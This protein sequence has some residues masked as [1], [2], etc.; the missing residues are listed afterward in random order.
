MRVAVTGS[1]GF[2]GGYVTKA[3]IQHG[4]DVIELSSDLRDRSALRRDVA[5]RQFDALIHLAGSAFAGSG[6]WEDFF[7]INHLGTCNLLETVADFYP[8]AL[9][10]LASTAQVY[11]NRVSG[12]IEE[13]EPFQPA[14]PYGISK[15]AMELSS[16]I[17]SNV[18]D[19]QIVRPFN[20]TGV[21]QSTQYLIPKIVAHFAQRIHTI[22]L[23]NLSIRRD[24]GD[25]RS[26]ATAYCSLLSYLS[27]N[28][29]PREPIN[30]ATGSVWSIHEIIDELSAST[31]HAPEIRINPQFVRRD[32]PEV[33]GGN[34]NRI[35]SICPSWEPI[36]FNETLSWMLNSYQR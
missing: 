30:I 3:L 5:Q 8:G 21:G 35:R 28:S 29:S 34:I 23:G 36:A 14:S 16:K 1:N 20:Y 12:L 11:G 18:L 6:E 22:E 26:V 10:I 24:F 27:Q 31:G 33:L 13:T 15:C 25:V 19:I 7:L 2:T 9:C 32:D 17:W 4:H